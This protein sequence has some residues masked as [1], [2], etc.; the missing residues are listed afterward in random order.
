MNKDIIITIIIIIIIIIIIND[1]LW[2]ASTSLSTILSINPWN[3]PMHFPFL[4]ECWDFTVHGYNNIANGWGENK[5]EKKI[6]KLFQ[7]FYLRSI[8]EIIGHYFGLLG[9]PLSLIIF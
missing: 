6:S 5:W 4:L 9:L 3:L 8:L 7:G 2:C 1:R